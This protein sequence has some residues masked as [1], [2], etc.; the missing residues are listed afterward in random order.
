MSAGSTE[1]WVFLSGDMKIWAAKLWQLVSGRGAES[2][3]YPLHAS[4][5]AWSGSAV[6]DAAVK[7][8]AASNM[9]SRMLDSMSLLRKPESFVLRTRRLP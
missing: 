4:A 7:T 8:D 1:A 2:S 9:G 6:T 3:S 5:K